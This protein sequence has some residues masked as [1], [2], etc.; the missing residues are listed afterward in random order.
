MQVY[1]Y[2]LGSFATT[3]GAHKHYSLKQLELEFLKTL[4]SQYVILSQAFQHLEEPEQGQSRSIANHICVPKRLHMISPHG[5][6]LTSACSI[7][8]YQ[9]DEA[10]FDGMACTLRDILNFW[11]LRRQE[12]M[13]ALDQENLAPAGLR[14][15]CAYFKSGTEGFFDRAKQGTIIDYCEEYDFA[16][17]SF[18]WPPDTGMLDQ[19][20][21][22][23]IECRTKE[24]QEAADKQQCVGEELI[25]RHGEENIKVLYFG[26]SKAVLHMEVGLIIV[27]EVG[28]RKG[29]VMRKSH[30]YRRIGISFWY[31]EGDRNSSVAH[32]LKPLKGKFG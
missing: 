27:C 17:M 31:V 32:A 22:P 10:T 18:E 4:V 9:R 30:V 16:A 5:Q 1:G 13:A 28:S 3:R 2:K 7:S 23:I 8:V 15:R 25:A 12:T 29:F 24:L 14:Q 26:R 11:R 6:F 20:G 19:Q 21:D